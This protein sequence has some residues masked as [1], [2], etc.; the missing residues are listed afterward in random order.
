MTLQE[1]LDYHAHCTFVLLQESIGTTSCW[2]GFSCSHCCKVYS[3]R[4]VIVLELLLLYHR[5]SGSLLYVH[6]FASDGNE[7]IHINQALVHKGIVSKQ[8]TFPKRVHD[9][10]QPG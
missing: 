8:N 2:K 5:A 7:G 4:Q 9:S 6:L 3:V 10:L 1:T